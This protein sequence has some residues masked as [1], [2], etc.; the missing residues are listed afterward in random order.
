MPR[1]RSRARCGSWLYERDVSV[2]LSEHPKHLVPIPLCTLR[3]R[4]WSRT[5][6]G[7]QRSDALSALLPWARLGVGP[8]SGGS[9]GVGLGLMVDGSKAS[10][11]VAGGVVAIGQ[12]ARVTRTGR[13]GVSYWSRCCIQ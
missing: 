4:V 1:A 12:A 2:G 11:G 6:F 10:G 5:G 3:D 8:V 7:R 13:N 9:T